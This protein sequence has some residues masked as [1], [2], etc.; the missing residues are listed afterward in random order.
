MSARLRQLEQAE[1]EQRRLV[2]RALTELEAQVHMVR[3][4]V[5]DEELV[6][7]PDWRVKR[8]ETRV[9][10]VLEQ[11]QLLNARRTARVHRA[12]WEAS[13]LGAAS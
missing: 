7:V 6:G 5:E 3:V 12:A 4:D 8:V 1:M 9:A 10:T 2:R 11:L 13:A